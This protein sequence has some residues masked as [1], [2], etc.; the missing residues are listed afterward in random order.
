MPTKALV[1]TVNQIFANLEGKNIST[2]YM[3]RKKI[4]NFL[5]YAKSWQLI[6][7]TISSQLEQNRL[8]NQELI[9]KFC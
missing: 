8:I 1:K 4:N 3:N 2:S 6:M 5:N 9:V 7:K